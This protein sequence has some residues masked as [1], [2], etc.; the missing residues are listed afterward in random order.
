[1]SDG[2]KPMPFLQTPPRA[3]RDATL[4]LV[5]PMPLQKAEARIALPHVALLMPL[6]ASSP[7][8]S[9][10][11][12]PKPAGLGSMCNLPAQA[13]PT[14]H[15]LLEAAACSRAWQQQ[16]QPQFDIR[17]PELIMPVAIPPLARV[18]AGAAATEAMAT[19]TIATQTSV[20]VGPDAEAVLEATAHSRIW[21]QR[22]MP[23]C[24]SF[25]V[26]P[27]CQAQDVQIEQLQQHHLPATH[28]KD[29]VFLEPLCAL[30]PGT[31]AQVPQAM[32]APVWPSINTVPHHI[33]LHKDKCDMSMP[34][35]SCDI[36][37]D[38]G[39]N[40]QPCS[41]LQAPQRA[42]MIGEGC[43]AQVIHS[44]K[45][46]LHVKATVSVG[47]S[48]ADG[49]CQVEACW[50]TKLASSLSGAA[51]TAVHD[52]SSAVLKCSCHVNTGDRRWTCKL[53]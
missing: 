14:G 28:Q 7:P 42:N 23:P 1:M 37:L 5:T 13:W 3:T 41:L 36:A 35:C 22:H 40:L 24:V 34:D 51:A 20:E 11:P 52:A 29:C 26:Q 12:A 49:S 50:P 21:Q 10:T 33:R 32:C 31:A 45:Q 18:P 30:I 53:L 27:A 9:S 15:A 6:H 48:D 2:C 38:T 17:Q 19:Q 8:S 4:Q 44:C 16:L 47:V 43:M 46:Q 25:H 39:S